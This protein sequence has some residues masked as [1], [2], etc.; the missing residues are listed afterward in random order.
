MVED[1]QS[2]LAMIAAARGVG[3][4]HRTVR[5]AERSITRGGCRT[6]ET[7]PRDKRLGAAQEQGGVAM[8]SGYDRLPGRTVRTSRRR[9]IGGAAAVGAAAASAN[10][11]A[12][13]GKSSGNKGGAASTSAVA[14]DS[15]KGNPG[16]T[17]KF[18]GAAYPLNFTVTE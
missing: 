16:G 7:L 11:A 1:G 17:L 4:L 15:S 14:V 5:Y 13:R 6:G 10:L 2:H 9:L 8:G 3:L 18:M 12:C